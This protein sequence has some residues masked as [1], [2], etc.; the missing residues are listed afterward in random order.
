MRPAVERDVPHGVI[1]RQ[2]ISLVLGTWRAD[3]RSLTVETSDPELRVAADCI[4]T[5]PMLIPHHPAEKWVAADAESAA[6]EPPA[7]QKY[8]L[9]FM[10]EMESAGYELEQLY[11]E[12]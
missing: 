8:L 2:G 6:F 12:E 7:K 4:L 10:A 5:T 11:D 9:L 1:R 3:L